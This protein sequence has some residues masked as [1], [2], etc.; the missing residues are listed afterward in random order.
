MDDATEITTQFLCA[1]CVRQGHEAAAQAAASVVHAAATI[2]W[3]EGGKER[4]LNV[5][6]RTSAA[7]KRM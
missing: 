1:V 2:L 4:A 6:A 5:L 3:R 7:I